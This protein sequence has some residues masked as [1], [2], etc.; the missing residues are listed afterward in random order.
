MHA[1]TSARTPNQDASSASSRSRASLASAIAPSDSIAVTG[2]V[3]PASTIARLMG[4]VSSAIGRSL[5]RANRTSATVQP[6]PTGVYI[7]RGAGSRRLVYFVSRAT[8]TTSLPW[9]RRPRAF[10]FPKYCRAIV[11]LMMATCAAGGSSPMANAR[12]ATIVVDVVSKKCGPTCIIAHVTSAAATAGTGAERALERARGSNRGQESD[13]ERHRERHDD[14][15]RQRPRV[16]RGVERG[17]G[18]RRRVT[19]DRPPRERHERDAADRGQ[20]DEERVFGH[21]LLDNPGASTAER[22]PHGELPSSSGGAGEQERPDVRTGN[23]QHG[24]HAD[25][26]RVQRLRES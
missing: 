23:E 10:V 14:D 12:P 16:G 13:D 26:Q 7:M 17:G 22:Q 18:R 6:A 9:M 20:G 3:T 1:S 24:R 19:Q 2:C 25:Q 21:E 5:C 11:S 15:E 8:P 4:P